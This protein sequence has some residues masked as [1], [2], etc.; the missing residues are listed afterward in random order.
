MYVTGNPKEREK[1]YLK[2]QQIKIS[3]IYCK[4]SIYRLNTLNRL[5]QDKHR[6]LK[7]TKEKKLNATSQ[8]KSYIIHKKIR[9]KIRAHF[10][11]ET[12]QDRK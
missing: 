12:M 10:L 11:P 1:K 6:V 4:L 3:Q 8:N 5:K 2:K 9:L 7:S